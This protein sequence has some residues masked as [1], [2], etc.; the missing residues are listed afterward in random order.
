[1]AS[2]QRYG[3]AMRYSIIINIQRLHL[4]TLPIIATAEIKN[5]SDLLVVF[6]DLLLSQLS[7]D[8]YRKLPWP[9]Q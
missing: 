9:Q 1:M 8:G 2:G 7:D 5:D 6:V 4:V 3:S